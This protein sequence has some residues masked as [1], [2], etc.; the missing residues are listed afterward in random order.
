M[1]AG[2]HQ[3]ERPPKAVTIIQL[4]ILSRRPTD[5][6][7][8]RL[9]F[10]L[11]VKQPNASSFRFGI[12]SLVAAPNLT[13]LGSGTIGRLPKWTGLTSSNSFIGDST[14]FEDKFGKVGIGT[15]TPASRLTVAGMIETTLGGYKFPDGTVQTTAALSSIFH[16]AS[17]MGSG[18]SE[19][20]L[21]IAIGGV[22]AVHIGNG[23]VVQVSMGCLTTFSWRVGR[24][25]LS[26]PQATR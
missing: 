1:F 10:Y 2:R 24:T 7:G 6:N 8:P 12:T 18:T 16:D 17:L 19:S 14:I 26:P 11:P 21:G 25:S 20:P 9:V 22:Q 3:S 15:D 13:V 4:E 23:T 5:R